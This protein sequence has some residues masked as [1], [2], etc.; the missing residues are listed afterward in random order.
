VTE[1]RRGLFLGAA[2][3]G[4]WGL[5]PLYWP[6]LEPTEAGEILA[7][8]IVWS[9][10]LTG[11]LLAATRR[12]AALRAMWATPRVRYPMIAAG[13]V[14][15]LNWGTYIWGVNHGHVVET[16][17]G[18]Y[19]N[20]LV[21]VLLGVVVLKERLRRAQWLAL[22]VAGVAVVVLSVQVGHPPWIS[23]ILA[24]SFGTYGLVKKQVSVGPVEGLTYEGL[25]LAPV[26]LGYIAWLTVTGQSTAWGQ[27]P[28][29]ILLLA[30]T[31]VITAAPLLCFAGSANRVSL[32]TLG[33]L[34]YI[35][36][37]IQLFLGV[38]VFS[39]PMGALR[40]VGFSLVWVAL[41][42]FTADSVAAY[43]RRPPTDRPSPEESPASRRG[44]T[45]L[46]PEEAAA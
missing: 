16:S 18:Y 9:L 12:T 32:T 21:T 27:G 39:E 40:W 14:I 7:Q 46:P 28:V 6:L 38:V 44:V 25:V 31:G 29:H 4:L 1:E 19:I 30:G 26:A 11:V 22:A 13:V 42:I 33:M 35:A 5:F 2:A 8:R 24:F 45:S 43:R 37:T 20:P 10:V 3:F 17:L 23:L 34:Q 36:P 41:A 15:C